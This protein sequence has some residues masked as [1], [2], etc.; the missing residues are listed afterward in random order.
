[1]KFSVIIPT[2]NRPALFGAALESVLAQAGVALE[3]IVVNDGCDPAFLPEYQP[4]WDAAGDRLQVIHL[5][6]SPRGHGQSHALNM[7]VAASS[8]DYVTFLDDDDA[9][10][11]A[12]YL[13]RLAG[14]I[15]A[16]DR[17][18][19]LL[20]SDQ[21]AFR[22]DERVLRTVWIED[23]AETLKATHAPDAFGA[24]SVTPPDLLRA[25]GFCH[26]NTTV[27]RR[28]LFLEIGGL[29]ENIRYECDRDFYLRAIDAAGLIKYRPGVVSRHNIPDPKSKASMSTTV[30]ALEKQVFQIRVLDRGILFARSPAIRAHARRHK[31]YVLKAMAEELARAG[32]FATAGYYAREALL[33]AFGVKWLA[34]SLYLTVRGSFSAA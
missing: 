22:N 10:S 20:L 18:V 33:V 17:P 31:G 13:G 11:D 25:H 26:L 15:G 27:V 21:A 2:R 32:Q 14:I 6:I 3:I 5:P 34:Y 4:I 28:A 23:L 9:W 19:D 12:G 16:A 7:G 29:D 1:M 8:G 24:Y 30:S